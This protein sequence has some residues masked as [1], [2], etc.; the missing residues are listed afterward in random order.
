[1]VIDIL[2]ALMDV[3]HTQPEMGYCRNPSLGFVTKAR[4][5]KGAGQE[6]SLGVTFH[7]LG[8]VGE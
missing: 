7:V 4:V 1:M 8:N 3:V 6:G 2:G 5:Y